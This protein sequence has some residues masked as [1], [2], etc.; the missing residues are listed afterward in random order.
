GFFRWSGIFYFSISKWH[1]GSLRVLVKRKSNQL[2]QHFYQQ[3]SVDSSGFYRTR[4]NLK[5]G[6]TS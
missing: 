3:S 2:Y 5:K 6:I 4:V 1:D